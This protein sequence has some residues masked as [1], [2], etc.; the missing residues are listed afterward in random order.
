MQARLV[1][2]LCCSFACFMQWL[3]TGCRSIAR[4]RACRSADPLGK[5]SSGYATVI[6]GSTHAAA[7]TSAALDWQGIELASSNFRPSVR[8]CGTAMLLNEVQEQ[9]VDCGVG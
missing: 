1:C 6:I 2:G 7:R 8:A 5:T 3:E 4:P 9:R